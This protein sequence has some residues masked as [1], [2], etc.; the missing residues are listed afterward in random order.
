[1]ASEMVGATPGGQGKTRDMAGYP[2]RCTCALVVHP[3]E[4]GAVIMAVIDWRRVPEAARR[5]L[6]R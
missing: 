5:G 6:P 3:V 4:A 2:A 1:M